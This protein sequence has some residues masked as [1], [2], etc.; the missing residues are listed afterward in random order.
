MSDGSEEITRVCF[1]LPQSACMSDPTATFNVFGD[2]VAAEQAAAAADEEARCAA[3]QDLLARGGAHAEAGRLEEA[4]GAWTAGLA[5]Q[6]PGPVRARLHESCAQVR[7]LRGEWFAA[8]EAASAAATADP[9]W[10]AAHATLAHAQLALGEPSLAVRTL[11]IALACLAA[12]GDAD[13]G[14]VRA[15]L[16]ADLAEARALAQTAQQRR[17]AVADSRSVCWTG[18]EGQLPV[19]GPPSSSGGDDCP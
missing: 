18:R 4:L 3:A 12:V 7:L 13:P 17:A 19:L 16:E 8:V 15:D 10:P 1:A 6:P 11:E 9:A 14:V 2:A 5:A